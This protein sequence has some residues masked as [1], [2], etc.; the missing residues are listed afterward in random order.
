MGVWKRGGLG[1]NDLRKV[2]FERVWTG[3]YLFWLVD[4]GIVVRDDLSCSCE[5]VSSIVT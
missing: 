3:G 5:G 1:W 2:G 4:V